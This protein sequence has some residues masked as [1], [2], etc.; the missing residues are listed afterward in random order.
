MLIIIDTPLPVLIGLASSFAL[1]S[2]NDFCGD[3][4]QGQRKDN[5]GQRR[6][7]SDSGSDA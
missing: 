6:T 4:N 1:A 5:R 7:K 3:Q 2:K